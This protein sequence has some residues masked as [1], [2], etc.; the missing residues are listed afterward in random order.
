MAPAAFLISVLALS[1]VLCKCHGIDSHWKGG[2][3]ILHSRQERQ[4]RFFHVAMKMANSNASLTARPAVIE[5]G[6]M[7]TLTW[8]GV[9]PVA[10]KSWISVYCPQDAVDSDWLDYVYLQTDSQEGR[11]EVGPLVNMRCVYEFR[12]FIKEGVQASCHSNTV[13]FHRGTSQP[14]Q[15]RLSLVGDRVSVFSELKYI[16]QVIGIYCG[17]SDPS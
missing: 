17:V 2:A 12:F 14:L 8:R 6:G 3:N 11:I 16:N 1:P 7:V 10:G 4:P 15:G 13:S 5:Q 9:K